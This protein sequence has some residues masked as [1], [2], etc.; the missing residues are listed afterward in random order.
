MQTSWEPGYDNRDE[1]IYLARTLL[2]DPVTV[3]QGNYLYSIG[4]FTVAAV[5]LEQATGR[6]FEQL[7]TEELFT[8]LGMEGCGFGPTTTDPS[9]PP[10]QPWGHISDQVGIWN[11]GL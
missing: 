6:T 4:A 2:E 9:L 7:M 3:L 5:M 8:P 1:R 11:I 10:V